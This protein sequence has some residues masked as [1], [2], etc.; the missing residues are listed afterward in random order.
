MERTIIKNILISEGAKDFILAET[1]FDTLLEISP[2]IF[3][4]RKS[5]VNGSKYFPMLIDENIKSCFA[6][7]KRKAVRE[8]KFK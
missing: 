8:M 4:Q 5:E 1:H 3:L 2:G 7:T 6:L